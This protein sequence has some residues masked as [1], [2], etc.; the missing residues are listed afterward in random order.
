MNTRLVLLLTRDRDFEK[1]LTRAVLET[2]AA[3]I[4][5]ARTVGDA[6]HVVCTR[7]RELDFAVIDFDD[8]CHGMTL[9]S[10][11][12]TC[13]HGLPVVVAT[14]QDVYH[15][16]AVAYANGVAAC[17]AKPIG[18]SDLEIVIRELRNPKLELEAA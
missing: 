18:A 5:V 17:L 12:D 16:A 1:L 4:L 8:G 3:A 14:S 6:L 7:G 9:L 13:R 2:G 15:A 10:A 11:L